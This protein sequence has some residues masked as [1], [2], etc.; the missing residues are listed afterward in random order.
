MSLLPPVVDILQ[1]VDS[2]RLQSNLLFSWGKMKFLWNCLLK[3]VFPKKISCF[4]QARTWRV[5]LARNK[6]VII[7]ITT[8]SEYFLITHSYFCYDMCVTTPFHSMP[9]SRLP[10]FHCYDAAPLQWELRKRQVWK[11]QSV[12]NSYV[13]YFQ[14]L[15]TYSWTKS[16]CRQFDGYEWI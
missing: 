10:L 11:W 14:I 2:E 3:H 15:T 4:R 9:I 7:T 13:R 5:V 1:L 12:V 6:H 8:L 16:I